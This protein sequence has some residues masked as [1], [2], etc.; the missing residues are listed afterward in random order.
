[1]P[2]SS[3]FDHPDSRMRS[4]TGDTDLWSMPLDQPQSSVPLGHAPV[5]GPDPMARLVS[6]SR[7]R[8]K[9]D[10]AR[11]RGSVPHGSSVSSTHH[12]PGPR[13]MA[14]SV[15]RDEPDEGLYIP[16]EYLNHFAGPTEPI[17]TDRSAPI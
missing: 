11:P 6:K 16:P 10:M 4:S 9:A 1:M 14:R 15:D 2:G 7:A 13:T 8:Q 3:Q 12:M 17:H 5:P